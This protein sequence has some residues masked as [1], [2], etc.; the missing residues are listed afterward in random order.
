[1]SWTK[2]GNPI[3]IKKKDKRIKADWDL[4]DDS[5]FLEIKESTAEDSGEYS[6]VAKN[7]GGTVESTVKVTVKEPVVEEAPKEEP[8]DEPK[9]EPKKKP[10]EEPQEEEIK[11]EVEEKVEA[12]CK[13]EEVL[14]LPQ[15][16]TEPQ[17]IN[18]KLGETIKLTCKASG[19][20]FVTLLV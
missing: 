2:D 20:H 19:K 3:K 5:Y 6:V 14:P 8:K 7:E 15:F 16:D 17:P 18:V 4:K 1:M 9:E 11:P 12:A 10:K 13:K